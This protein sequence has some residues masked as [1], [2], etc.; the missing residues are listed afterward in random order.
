MDDVDFICQHMANVKPYV[1]LARYDDKKPAIYKSETGNFFLGQPQMLSDFTGTL[2]GS[3]QMY[4]P[5]DTTAEYF[6]QIWRQFFEKRINAKGE[7]EEVWIHGYAGD[8]KATESGT[9]PDHY[10]DCFNLSYA[11]AKLAGLDKRLFNEDYC[12]QTKVN[13][14]KVVDFVE[15]A[16]KPRQVE[17]K[18][19]RNDPSFRRQGGYFK[20]SYGRGWR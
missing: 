20:R 2:L 9:G 18:P 8:G 13:K 5:E 6:D 4:F 16:P 14:A 3:D 17:E 12:K 7:Q 11:A 15:A 19:N 10:R 1:G